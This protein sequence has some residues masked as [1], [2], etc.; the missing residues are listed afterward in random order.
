MLLANRTFC[1]C[2]FILTLASN[3]N[4]SNEKKDLL[5]PLLLHI[6][7]SQ[8]ILELQFLEL[9]CAFINGSLLSTSPFVL[10][11]AHLD[12]AKLT[13]SFFRSPGISLSVR[14]LHF[15]CHIRP[16]DDS[17][18]GEREKQIANARKK[19]A[20]A[21]LDPLGASVHSAAASHANGGASSSTFKVFMTN[22][23]LQALQVELHDVSAE[24]Q[25]NPLDCCKSLY[26]LSLECLTVEEGY[27][28]AGAFVRRL[29]N[30]SN[31][32][33]YSL[34]KICSVEKFSLW[35]S[36]LEEPSGHVKPDDLS[37]G[38]NGLKSNELSVEY[39]TLLWKTV[40]I[41]TG[42][43]NSELNEIDA[44]FAETVIQFSLA[45][46]E[47]I[48][49]TINQLQGPPKGSQKAYLSKERQ[50]TCTGARYLWQRAFEKITGGS[51]RK[52]KS[53]VEAGLV[54]QKYSQLYASWLLQAG[55]GIIDDIG[56][57]S[58]R[59]GF[60]GKRHVLV[61]VE[62]DLSGL[63]QEL[64]VEAIVLARFLGRSKVLT[65]LKR[66]HVMT[67][68]PLGSALCSK[69]VSCVSALWHAL[70]RFYRTLLR[71]LKSLLRFLCIFVERFFNISSVKW[72]LQR[73]VKSILLLGRRL[74]LTKASSGPN[75]QQPQLPTVSEVLDK[76]RL[77][78]SK[79]MEGRT[80]F[81]ST[82]TTGSVTFIGSKECF[83]RNLGRKLSRASGINLLEGENVPGVRFSFGNLSVVYSLQAT[84]L[85]FELVC[86]HLQGQVVTLPV[87]HPDTGTDS[88]RHILLIEDGAMFFQSGCAPHLHLPAEVKNQFNSCEKG[89]S[90]FLNFL[91][92]EMV[93]VRGFS[94]KAHET[95]VRPFIIC[96]YES[97]ENGH[98]PPDRNIAMTMCRLAVGC[99]NCKIDME[100]YGLL[101]LLMVQLLD[102]V[103]VTRQPISEEDFQSKINCSARSD[104]TVV[105]ADQFRQFVSS[106]VFKQ[107]IWLSLALAGPKIEFS[108]IIVGSASSSNAADGGFAFKPVLLMDLGLLELTIWPAVV[109]QDNSHAEK[110]DDALKQPFY[111]TRKRKVWLMDPP[112]PYIQGDEVVQGSS[113]HEEIGNNGIVSLHGSVIS[114]RRPENK[115]LVRPLN[116]LWKFALC[117]DHF[118]SSIGVCNI[119][120]AAVIGSCS[121]IQVE[122][123]FEE[124]ELLFEAFKK[125]LMTTPEFSSMKTTDQEAVRCGG[126]QELRPVDETS[127]G[128]EISVSL[129]PQ[130]LYYAVSLEV[131]VDEVGFS[132]SDKRIIPG[133]GIRRSVAEQKLLPNECL[134]MHKR[135]DL[136]SIRNLWLKFLWGDGCTL[137]FSSG[138]DESSLLLAKNLSECS[139]NST[140]VSTTSNTLERKDAILEAKDDN[141]HESGK[142]QLLLQGFIFRISGPWY[143]SDVETLTSTI[144]EKDKDLEQ[145]NKKCWMRLEFQMEKFHVDDGGESNNL[146]NKA[147]SRWDGGSC[148]TIVVTFSA[149]CKRISVIS[150]GGLLFLQTKALLIS[151]QELRSILSFRMV[152]MDTTGGELIF[153][154]HSNNRSKDE[155]LIL[156]PR[157]GRSLSLPSR[158]PQDGEFHQERLY[159]A[160][161]ELGILDEQEPF[162]AISENHIWL[163]EDFR[164]EISG[165]CFVLAQ[166]KTT[167]SGKEQGAVL[168][169]VGGSSKV[170]TSVTGQLLNLETTRLR[171]SIFSEEKKSGEITGQFSRIPRFGSS[172]T[173]HT[174]E[175]S[176]IDIKDN[177]FSIDDGEI[178]TKSGRV[179]LED[180][181]KNSRE[182]LV[183]K[184]END[185]IV[186]NLTISLNLENHTGYLSQS[187][188]WSGSCA[189]LGL[190]IG[191]TIPEVELLLALISSISSLPQPLVKDESKE[192][193]DSSV[194]PSK[195]PSDNDFQVPD[196]SIVAVKDVQEHLYMAVEKANNDSYRLIGVLHYSLVGDRAFFK[197]KYQKNSRDTSERW[198]SLLSVCAKN[199]DGEAFRVHYRPGSGLADISS[200]H[201]GSW[202]LWQAH[203]YKYSSKEGD[204]DIALYSDLNRN[205]F[206]LVNQKSKQGL[207]LASGAPMMVKQPGSPLKFKLLQSGMR[208]PP[209]AQ[210]EM[211]NLSLSAHDS[212]RNL[213][214]PVASIPQVEV[215]VGRIC[216]SLLHESGG[217]KY[218]LPL[219]RGSTE[220]TEAVL[221]IQP[222]KIRVIGG[223]KFVFEYLEAHVNQWSMIIHPVDIG[224]FYRARIGGKRNVDRVKLPVSFFARCKRVDITLS[225]KSLDIILFAIGILKLAGPYSIKHSPVLATSCLV[226]NNT[227]LDLCCSFESQGYKK[228]MKIPAWGTD[229]FFVRNLISRRDLW[230]AKTLSSVSFNLEKGGVG[231]SSPVHASL[232]EPSLTATR[233]RLEREDGRKKTAG[234]ILVV[235]VS[236][237]SQDGIIV[238]VSPM[239]RIHNCSGLSMELRCRRPHGDAEGASVFLKD[240]DI[241]DDSM[242]AFDALNLKGELKKALSSF[243]LGDYLLSVRPVGHVPAFCV[244]SE[245][246]TVEEFDWSED[247]KGAKPIQI[248]GFFEKLQYGFKKSLKG[249]S[250]SHSFGTVFCAVNLK[251]EEKANFSKR[252]QGMHILV[253]FTCRY[254]PLLSGDANDKPDGSRPTVAWLEQKELVLLPT[255][256]VHNFL[257]MKISISSKVGAG[258]HAFESHSSIERTCKVS[259]FAD[260]TDLM[261]AI[262]L[263]QL[264]L[265][266]KEISIKEWSRSVEQSTARADSVKELEIDLDFGDDNWCARLK[267]FRANDGVLQVL[268]YSQYAVKNSNDLAL[269]FCMPKQSGFLRNLWNRG[270][271]VLWPSGE[272]GT[273]LNSGS[274]MS[275]LKRSSHLLLQMAERLSETASLDLESFSGSTELSLKIYHEDGLI[276]ETKLGVRMEV[277]AAG[278]LDPTRTISIGSRYIALNDSQE[279]IY[280]CQDGLQEDENAAFSLKAGEHISLKT[281]YYPGPKRS[282]LGYSQL[283]GS[284]AA[285]SSICSIRFCFQQ[286]DWDWSGPVCASALG[287]FS[288]RVHKRLDNLG[289]GDTVETSD[290]TTFKYISVDVEDKSPSLLIRFRTQST[291][292][293]PYRIENALSQA[294]IYFYQKGLSDLVTTLKPRQIVGY[295]WDNLSHPH[296]LVVG[297]SGTQ[298][299]NEIKLDKLGPWKSFRAWRQRK[300]LCLQLPFENQPDSNL[301]PDITS[302]DLSLSLD[303]MKV[304]YEIGADGLQRVLRICEDALSSKLTKWPSHISFP[305]ARLNFR[306]PAFGITLVEDLKQR[307]TGGIRETSDD[308]YR[309][310]PII[311]M[312]MSNLF[313]EVL[314]TQ[315]YFL[316]QMKVETLSVDE[317]WEGAPF[318]AMM[319]VHSEDRFKKGET[320]LHMAAIIS[321]QASN[322]I[323]V[324]YSSILLQTIDVNLDEET[325]MKLVPFYRYSLSESTSSRQLYFERFE[326]HPIKIVASFIP[327]KPLADYTSMQETFRTL[328]HSFIKVPPIRG[329]TIE[330][331]GVLLTHGLM[332]FRQLA[333]KCAQHYSWY[334]MRAVYVVKG[335][336][337][338][339]PAFTS[340]FDD[341]AASS[342]DV[343][344]DPSNGSVDLQG[345]TLGMFNFL[346]DGLKNRGFSGTSRYIGNLEHTMKTAGSNILFAILTEISDNVLKGAET[347]GIDGMVNGFRRG[348][349]NV[350]ME[351]SLLRTAV[352]KGG[353]S[354]RIKLDNSPG[355]DETYVEGYLQA[356]LDT[357][358]QQHYLKVKVVDDQVLLKNLPP[359]SA[360]VDE[361]MGSVKSFLVREGLLVGE[362]SA[363]AIHSWRRLQGENDKRIIPAVAALSEQLFVIFAVRALRNQARSW[364]SWGENSSRIKNP[365]WN[366]F[367]KKDADEKDQPDTDKSRGMKGILFSFILSSAMAYIDGRLCRH[368]PNTLARRVVSGFLLSFVE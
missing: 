357:L 46:A 312:R 65:D 42:F 247:I 326:I 262:N 40:T 339:P 82:F 195:Q 146:R 293:V 289:V 89:L 338:L 153:T 118:I 27:G 297:I 6:H 199:K 52:F 37:N 144:S 306:V 225:E 344:F 209:S 291:D 3:A 20:I 180:D 79:N 67:P 177:T 334:A 252:S 32:A 138:F 300:V 316:F 81:N 172:F 215:K 100:T 176:G 283:V 93:S 269:L 363:T 71:M 160:P 13:I 320:V 299:H 113:Q 220:D 255:L 106:V 26:S 346:T 194:T 296:K 310:S 303:S 8:I 282:R 164:M 188:G 78:R 134:L 11:H 108:G 130:C 96:S 136:F 49:F 217:G 85:G 218:L 31:K 274:K 63:E 139:K 313:C 154:S 116:I 170:Q 232:L 53:A 184:D 222:L 124:V 266:S 168:L 179:L 98:V 349:L 366:P 131:N 51:W 12:H 173:L 235:E 317:R 368:I 305:S 104:W 48:I 165:L 254:L 137:L 38:L 95:N 103:R 66:R 80:Y 187:Q 83:V 120:S 30:V 2:G 115:E 105:Y 212:S 292:G 294:S 203:L 275:L 302:G 35:L 361:I 97:T 301:P 102:T 216:F 267:I 145:T 24:L 336:K 163:P 128:Q 284:D 122:I 70:E 208:I 127:T 365:S 4:V 107:E 84:A 256:C 330:L 28:L 87:G 121:P 5:E 43:Q 33:D 14:G 162:A 281:Q 198:F 358:Y 231:L 265:A 47:A 308:V 329:A 132:L 246:D 307:D 178:S 159:S 206:H 68:Q 60:Q 112:S 74:Y 268:V 148:L 183:V 191:I 91:G 352:V 239:T 234:P 181:E 242:G 119:V 56:L 58:F 211:Q 190:D 44:L 277:T 276:E 337:L 360:L 228:V 248:S 156:P 143:L 309:V 333:I 287:S 226:E 39:Y 16:P 202:E 279:A 161:F 192:S 272:A 171:L 355:T 111:G 263:D 155:G 19:E 362:A 351:P 109:Q 186:E 311:S 324:K 135:A 110:R 219:L 270:G 25:S 259:L 273:V 286:K 350:S 229:T 249:Q 353:S 328:L 201:D 298:L 304:G 343:F 348:I 175:S 189:L 90:S 258:K 278:S 340:L 251:E 359:N 94:E 325:L 152:S 158:Q 123:L 99:M 280:V 140:N 149:D 185:Y 210:V 221:H 238:T 196:G 141:E 23:V 322:P 245:N 335:S 174:G 166:H 327:G 59:K 364:F 204:G 237:Q 342:L 151:L 207:S 77:L 290:D 41:Y 345:L 114:L 50:R 142:C 321:N 193:N 129:P 241:V 240:G 21:A 332:T 271:K 17:F 117:R 169:E 318:S 250:A 224:L 125:I 243:G 347:G 236:K 88:K 147:L 69:I 157:L 205:M 213:S 182:G 257:D 285:N 288:L 295:A 167:S 253:R 75:I 92:K 73:C 61:S 54:R 64:P 214:G 261:L 18:W 86:G 36:S 197:V 57:L 29:T 62:K 260:L 45:E 331:N 354:R 314:N 10:G 72:I 15:I 34:C 223:C 319:R 133:K 341:S 150:K 356:M 101:G 244:G 264:R 315:K 323:H 230:P 9:D 126:K 227:G 76:S 200:T 7:L 233:T 367:I 1:R 55:E 22:L